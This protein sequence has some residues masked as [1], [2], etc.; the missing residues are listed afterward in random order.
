VEAHIEA[1][2]QTDIMNMI[3]E[4]MNL[5]III[6]ITNKMLISDFFKPVK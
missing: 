1:K 3:G 6:P 4:I 5:T 2:E